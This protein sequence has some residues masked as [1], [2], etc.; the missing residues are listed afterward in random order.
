LH[1][2]LS[3][4]SGLMVI[5]LEYPDYVSKD[6]RQ[7]SAIQINSD[8]IKERWQG[9][10]RLFAARWV[11]KH[12]FLKRSTI[13]QHERL[14]ID[15][16]PVIN[17]HLMTTFI[18]QFGLQS[19]FVEALFRDLCRRFDD[20]F[21][22]F[23]SIVFNESEGWSPICH[24]EQ[25]S[26]W[27]QIDTDIWGPISAEEAAEPAIPEQG[28][29]N[30]NSE[31][32]LPKLEILH[33]RSPRRKQARSERPFGAQLWEVRDLF[34][35]GGT[36]SREEA[37][38]ELMRSTGD[39]VQEIRKVLHLAVGRG[40]VCKTDD[41]RLRLGARSI[42]GYQRDFLKSQFVVS[43]PRRRWHGLEDSTR[44]FASWMGFRRSGPS[45]KKT[46]LSLVRALTR[47]GRIE[48]SG[49]SVRR[50]E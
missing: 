38:V 29:E 12:S 9:Y 43:M 32:T 50:I 45:F 21:F 2:S 27:E 36:R 8:D 22:R 1:H 13:W 30:T 47:E 39:G 15:F 49:P 6:G 26:A 34:R 25:G 48:R 5:R 17:H 20:K 28:V 40:I 42:T 24:I 44:K 19:R 7:L 4:W 37:V 11:G 3:I 10:V 46:T 18:C 35:R 14:S 31:V 16:Q 33:H 23:D 41:G